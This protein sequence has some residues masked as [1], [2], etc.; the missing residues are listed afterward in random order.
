MIINQI[1]NF[2]QSFRKNCMLRWAPKYMNGHSSCRS[3]CLM[4]YSDGRYCKH[5]RSVRSIKP[6]FIV[7]RTRAHLQKQKISARSFFCSFLALFSW[8]QP[9]PV[10]DF[11]AHLMMMPLRPQWGRGHYPLCGSK[12]YP[13]IVYLVSFD[14]SH[15]ARSFDGLFSLS[16]HF[17]HIRT[18]PP[19]QSTGSGAG[20]ASHLVTEVVTRSRHWTG[21]FVLGMWALGSI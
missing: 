13:P 1:H 6:S 19:T 11:I 20:R 8:R 21:N 18:C 7:R 15:P 4:V 5:H 2:S 17:L 16:S 12:S 14:S 3:A 9:W 10:L